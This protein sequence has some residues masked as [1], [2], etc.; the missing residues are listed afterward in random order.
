MKSK[1]L[2]IILIILSFLKNI[3]LASEIKINVKIEN[4]IITNIDIENEENYLFFL[5]PKL[6]QLSNKDSENIAKN[7]LI[8][9]IIKKKELKKYF[10]IKKKYKFVDK[11]EKNLLLK[12]NINNKKEFIQLLEMNNLNY[13]HVRK[14]LKMEALWNQLI[15]KKYFNNLKIDKEKLKIRILNQKKNMKKKYEYNLSEIVFEIKTNENTQQIFNKINNSIKRIGFENTANIFSLSDTSNNGGL[16]GWINE[17]QISDKIN[18][19]LS[20]LNIDEVTNPIKIPNGYLVIKINDKKTF[21]QKFDVEK[22]LNNLIDI[23]TNKQL[24]NFSMIF[25]KR[26]KQNTVINEY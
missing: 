26:L 3:T 8:K 23:E 12:K 15:Y 1:K 22:Q 7:S 18:K 16:I 25:Y 6:K 19:E 11:I 17:L 14:K 10:D 13:S 20:S 2:F 4:E 24:N 5:N 21:N 9:E